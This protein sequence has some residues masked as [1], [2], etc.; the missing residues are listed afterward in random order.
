MHRTTFTL[1]FTVALTGISA[2]ASSSENQSE[3]TI[4]VEGV[5][6]GVFVTIS[7]VLESGTR[8]IAR[9]VTP[10]KQNV[11]T[12]ENFFI[13]LSSPKRKYGAI[14]RSAQ[15]AEIKGD[16]YT[17]DIK[18]DTPENEETRYVKS[19][20][21]NRLETEKIKTC[22]S[23]GLEDLADRP[24]ACYKMPPLLPP[25]TERSGWCKIAFA[26][27]MDGSVSDVE[28]RECSEDMFK[29]PSVETA[30]TFRYYPQ[31]KDGKV[32]RSCLRSTIRYT[33]TNGKGKVIPAKGE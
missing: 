10:C 5:K 16:T 14:R 15:D 12:N 29:I 18:L 4:R 6:R 3:K 9:C 27:L 11:S 20:I 30:K 23:F 24:K 17:F 13:T 33:L 28:A 21:A 19:T 1:L 32:V 26:V 31:L 25:L 2:S 22:M 8:S 7:E